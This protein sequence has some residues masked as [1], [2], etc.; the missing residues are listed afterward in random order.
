VINKNT[1]SD[2]FET[3][4]PKTKSEP[5]TGKQVLDSMEDDGGLPF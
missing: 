4:A 3:A 5:K 2:E 1:K